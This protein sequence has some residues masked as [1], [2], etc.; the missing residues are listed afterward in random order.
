MN[1]ED[2]LDMLMEDDDD[3]AVS[4]LTTALQHN[5]RLGETVEDGEN[6][7]DK[8]A[9]E[10]TGEEMKLVEPC[11]ELIKVHVCVCVCVRVHVHLISHLPLIR[12]LFSCA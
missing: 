8:G 2:D 9:R 6:A 7:Q 10:W 12:V 5:T 4:D 3:D 11:I 1:E